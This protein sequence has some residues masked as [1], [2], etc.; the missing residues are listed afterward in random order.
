M[1]MIHLVSRRKKQK[2]LFD[3]FF[4]STI[5]Q[6]FESSSITY[7]IPIY[8]MVWNPGGSVM[9]ILEPHYKVYETF[10]NENVVLCF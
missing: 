4:F 10:P 9:F 6:Q 5:Q 2:L 7:N 1:T 8:N 3:V